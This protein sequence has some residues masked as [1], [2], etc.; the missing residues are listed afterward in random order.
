L[1]L[2]EKLAGARLALLAPGSVWNTKRW[3]PEGYAQLATTL[4]ADGFKVLLIGA[5]NE[6]SLC[7]TVAAAAPGSVVVAGELTLWES[8]ELMA[9]AE[10]VVANDSGAMHLASVS[11]APTVAVFGPTV[12]AQGYRPWQTRARVVETALACRPCGKHGGDVCPIGTHACMKDISAVAV[13]RAATDLL[14]P[15]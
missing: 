14:G 12:L 10:L 4:L 15:K 3:T 6:K 9:L 13:M 2:R 1:A 11:D 5:E 8:A 7:E